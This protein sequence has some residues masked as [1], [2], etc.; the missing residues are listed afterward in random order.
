[1]Q[2]A[3]VQVK[4]VVDMIHKVHGTGSLTPLMR[5]AIQREETVFN[6]TRKKLHHANS[7]LAENYSMLASTLDAE[8]ARSVSE[9]MT[10]D[11]S[12]RSDAKT[13]LNHAENH[14]IVANKIMGQSSGQLTEGEMR[15]MRAEMEKLREKT[16]KEEQ[17]ARKAVEEEEKRRIVEAEKARHAS[18]EKAKKEKKQA[19]RMAQLRMKEAEIQKIREIKKAKKKADAAEHSKRKSELKK[20]AKILA[21]KKQ[22]W[23]LEKIEMKKMKREQE[24]ERHIDATH[25]AKFFLALL[26]DKLDPLLDVA[27]EN[28][29]QQRKEKVLYNKRML[30]EA[31][32]WEQEDDGSWL[33]WRNKNT[34]WDPPVCVKIMWEVT[35]EGAPAVTASGNDWETYYDDDG[36]PYFYNTITGESSY[37]NPIVSG[38]SGGGAEY[39][40][41]NYEQEY[42]GYDY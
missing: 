25:C 17:K 26:F 5:T 15:A 39:D 35:G 12:I 30:K 9:N 13:S 27:E 14:L 11:P 24:T 16:I 40:Q 41:Q 37:E 36:Y 33:N 38:G 19:E 8:R 32:N 6:A 28:A 34:Q 18:F 42:G 23:A 22:E 21:S 4:K 31:K 10:L 7:M 29:R 2:L 1:M 3:V 20:Q